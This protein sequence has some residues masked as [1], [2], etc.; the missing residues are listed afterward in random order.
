MRLDR[1]TLLGLLA[2]PM[3]ARARPRP[4]RADPPWLRRE[5]SAFGTR[6][7]LESPAQGAQA[8]EVEQALEAAHQ[9]VERIHVLLSG[10]TPG[11]DV[12]RI[13]AAA[14]SASVE[15]S[16]E[17]F[18]LVRRCLEL[19]ELSGGVFDVTYAS[20]SRLW[21]FDSAPGAAALPDPEEVARLRKLVDY[22][23]VVLDEARTAVML[24]SAQ[25]RLGLGGIARGYA[26]DRAARL[27]LGGGAS[28]FRAT[29]GGLRLCHGPQGPGGWPVG[30]PDPRAPD[31]VFASVELRDGACATLGDY[32]RFVLVGGR[33]YHPV[34]DPRTGFPARAS[35]AVTVL[36]PRALDADWL[37]KA[38]FILGPKDAAPVLA[39]VAGAQALWVTRDNAVE[40]TDGMKRRVK[41][42]GKPTD[43]EP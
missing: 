26:L 21:T 32:E 40:M 20:M 25:M 9:E 30:V 31:R 39:R 4:A 23:L 17:T 8:A 43:G 34:I 29:L 24:P 28:T 1:R 7:E 37:G 14:G 18:A 41:L 38:C 35:R 15:V 19:S 42:G 2:A 22:R 33:R 12:S 16:A 13:N 36:A 6:L 10:T 27:L 3:V 5:G 11:S